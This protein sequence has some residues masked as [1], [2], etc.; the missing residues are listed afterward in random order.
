MAGAGIR[1]IRLALMSIDKPIQIKTKNPREAAFLALW[2]ASRENVF[3]SDILDFWKAEENPGSLDFSL[4]R[5]IAFGTARMK[6][7]LDFIAGQ[8]SDKKKLNIKAKER[9]LIRSAI[10]QLR[11]MDKLPAYAVVNET[12][13]IGKKYCHETFVRFLNGALRS[14]AREMPEL[15]N[16]SSPKELGIRFSYPEFFVEE[17][18]SQ[19]GSE[20]TLSILKAQNLAGKTMARVRSENGISIA[21]QMG[22]EPLV[23]CSAKVLLITDPGLIGE[24]AKS[25]EVYLQNATPAELSFHLAKR[26]KVPKRILDLCASPGGKLLAAHDAF[27]EAALFANDVSE[28]KLKTLKENC[29]KYGIK[30]HLTCQ[31]GEEYRTDEP[32]DLVILDVPCSNSGVLNKRPEARWRISE[33]GLSELHDLQMALLKNA[34]ELVSPG[35][36]IWYLTCSILDRE[37]GGFIKQAAKE[38]PFKVIW[39]KAFFPDEQGIDGG[40]GALLCKL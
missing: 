5:E 36:E 10:Y 40:Y 22:T 19:L 9:V 29:A 28:N 34:L 35:G 20:K 17:L 31:R 25:K 4:A 32:F 24:L 38:L 11:F 23:S 39:D 26:S 30:A 27:P 14:L 21:G 6:A 16:G 33:E 2:K 18:I 12:I 7:A 37:N 3:L 1:E 15:P 13:E 8:I